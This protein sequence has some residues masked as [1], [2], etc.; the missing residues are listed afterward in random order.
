MGTRHNSLWTAGR[1]RGFSRVDRREYDPQDAAG[2]DR[3][4][5][6]ERTPST[7]GES[8]GYTGGGTLSLDAEDLREYSQG[9]R[10]EKAM[11]RP[12]GQRDAVWIVVVLFLSA[13]STYLVLRTRATYKN[14]TEIALLKVEVQTLRQ[15]IENDQ[16]ATR[17]ELSEIERTLYGQPPKATDTRRPSVLEQWQVN[18]YKEMQRR[19]TLLER[20]RYETER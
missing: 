7:V 5:T 15:A 14:E 8:A 10:G 2:F 9:F 13:V 12:L 3:Y 17:V 16:S 4:S 1:Y 11:F 20:W 18:Q 19:L 6:A